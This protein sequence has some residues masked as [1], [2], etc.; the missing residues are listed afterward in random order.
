M[1]LW[2]AQGIYGTPTC[3][4]GCSKY[5]VEHWPQSSRLPMMRDPTGRDAT[6]MSKVIKVLCKWIITNASY[7]NCFSILIMWFNRK[8]TILCGASWRAWNLIQPCSFGYLTSSTY[9]RLNK[10]LGLSL[11]SSLNRE[12]CEVSRLYF[13]VL[14]RCLKLAKSRAE[15]T[16]NKLQSLAWTTAGASATLGNSINR[17]KGFGLQ[18]CNRLKEFG[19]GKL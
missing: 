18:N 1:W 7:E 19:L 14:V 3:P 17:L 10:P 12:G 9:L 2:N 11:P 5:C 13:R 6:A 16:K 15:Q 8:V 4:M